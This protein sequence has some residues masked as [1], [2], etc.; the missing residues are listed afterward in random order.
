VKIAE[1]S[2]R[3]GLSWVEALDCVLHANFLNG[4]NSYYIGY[5]F[6]MAEQFIS[7]CAEWAETIGAIAQQIPFEQGAI[8]SFIDEEG[9][10]NYRLR[11]PNGRQIVALSSKPANLRSKKGRIVVDE[12]AFHTDV[13]ELLKAAMAITIWGG[14][15]RIISTHDGEANPFNDLVKQ[16]RTGEKPYSLHRI[17]FRDAIAQGLYR[18][19]AAVNG[20]AWTLESEFEWE[21]K[22]RELYG[23]GAS[24]ELDVIP[25]KVGKGLVF[26]EPWF[27]AVT[28]VDHSMI[29]KYSEVRFWDLAATE[30]DVTSKNPCYTSG[31]KMR[32]VGDLYYVV[33]VIKVQLNPADIDEVMAAAAELDGQACSIRW[34]QEGGSAGKRDAAHIAKLLNKYDAQG[35]LP[36]GDKVTRARPWASQLKAGNA[37]LLEGDWNKEYIDDHVKFPE[38]DKDSIDASSGAYDFLASSNMSASDFYAPGAAE[39]ALTPQS[40]L[41][42]LKR[43]GRGGA[44]GSAGLGGHVKR[45]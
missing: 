40:R 27:K 42:I 10:L 43:R 29:L 11:F 44:G 21:K 13:E 30:R 17:S 45:Y 7:D 38:G 14:Q 5:N 25:A 12:A 9:I 6:D 1:K 41:A 15:L 22:I 3:I 16:A 20:E 23:V 31:V 36:R 39:R 8:D 19:I 34:E 18:R 2:R 24:E 33:D 37:R 35:V 32:R 4:F 26:S 28:T